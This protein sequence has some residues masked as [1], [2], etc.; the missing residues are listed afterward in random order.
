M[1]VKHMLTGEMCLYQQTQIHCSYQL[2]WP[3]V[4][5]KQL[6]FIF[7]QIMIIAADY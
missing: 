1:N 6:L 5:V 7:T 2:K 4:A 3:L